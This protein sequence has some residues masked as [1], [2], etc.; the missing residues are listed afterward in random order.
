MYC[1]I[2]KG[3]LKRVRRRSG[4]Y[5]NCE[6]HVPDGVDYR[7][8]SWRFGAE[9][10]RP[11]RSRAWT[12][13]VRNSCRFKGK[14]TKACIYLFRKSV[15]AIYDAYKDSMIN[16]VAFDFFNTHTV[17]SAVT[18]KFPDSRDQII[19]MI[20]RKLGPVINAVIREFMVTDEYRCFREYV[21][22]RLDVDAKIKA[23]N[24]EDNKRAEDEK[25]RADDYRR[26][27]EEERRTR[28]DEQRRRAAEEL[29][30]PKTSRKDRVLGFA[31]EIARR[32]ARVA[33]MEFHPDRAK[34]GDAKANHEKSII[35]REVVD[36]TMPLL[37][38]FV[39][40]EFEQANS[41][42]CH[43]GI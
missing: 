21:K 11:L 4:V 15:Y 30:K 19:G 43:V 31:E 39:D 33:K 35:V 40:T 17:Q 28:E 14:H 34:S 9:I 29:A 38:T 27:S 10:I 22:L 20:K 32:F 24:A 23:L 42:N 5:E 41:D 1:N 25:R 6:Y 12:I 7:K 2:E 16:G 37:K 13:S 26:R 8:G 3:K 36:A 18:A